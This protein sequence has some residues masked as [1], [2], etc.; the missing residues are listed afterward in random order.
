MRYVGY[1]VTASILTCGGLSSERGLKY[2]RA[3]ARDRGELVFIGTSSLYRVTLRP[4]VI[5]IY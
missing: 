3:M 5:W 1:L 2:W 4:D